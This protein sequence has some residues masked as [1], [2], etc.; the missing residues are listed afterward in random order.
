[1]NVVTKKYTTIAE[2]PLLQPKGRRPVLLFLLMV[3]IL[4]FYAHWK[5]V[6][7]LVLDESGNVQISPERQK[8]LQKRLKQ[9]RK[10]RQYALL[11]TIDGYYPCFNCVQDSLI[12]L[13]RGE[14]WKYGVT[15]GAV[16]YSN[17]WL[18]RMNLVSQ[19]EYWGNIEDCLIQE[20]YKIYNYATLPEN[21]KRARPLIR[22]PGNKVDR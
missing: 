14:V 10:A 5:D 7:F 21:L 6:D 20:A 13:H 15:Y 22:P 8:E 19:T 16:R 12:Y 4:G 2:S 18:S 17:A 11:A 3:T 9:V 1:M